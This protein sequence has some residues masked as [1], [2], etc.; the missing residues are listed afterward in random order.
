MGAVAPQITAQEFARDVLLEC[1][2]IARTSI[3]E[4]GEVDTTAFIEA[5]C[6]GLSHPQHGPAVADYVG[7]Y[8]ARCMTGS[9]PNLDR[10]TLTG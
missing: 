3:A 1:E 6:L 9:V 10:W 8:L 4:S 7:H 5:L 2:S